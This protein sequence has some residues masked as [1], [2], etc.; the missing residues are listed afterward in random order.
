MKR[1]FFIVITGIL[2]LSTSCIEKQLTIDI[3]TYNIRNNNN[4]D[5]DGDNFWPYRKDFAANMIRFYD[6]D[7]VGTQ[8]VL[9]T[10]LKDLLD[11]LPEYN[12]LGVARDDGKESGEFC[13]LFFKKEKFELLDGSTF[14]LSE[15]PSAAGVKGWD[16][17][18]VRI[19]TWAIFKDKST[20]KKFAVFNT[21]FDHVG[22][23]ARVESAKLLVKKVDEIAKDL[24]VIITGDFNSVPETEVVKI[25]TDKSRSNYL[26]DSRSMASIKYGP[27]WTAHNFGRTPL[28]NR[29]II[30]YVFVNE[31]VKVG[32][33][34][35]IA[36]MLNKLYLSDHNP[37]F[38]NL[39][40]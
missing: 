25:I 13:A 15:D 4:P 11:S 1:V 5:A 23:I 38:V 6:V 29:R 27:E 7:I 31:K 37:V 36:E 40:M 19:V 21:H 34:A 30:D 28:E 14:W 22:P 17:D 33:H 9:I 12:Y 39:E 26:A 18:C 16:A 20:G 24:P 10:Q 8:E 3:M 35:V 2:L 32:K